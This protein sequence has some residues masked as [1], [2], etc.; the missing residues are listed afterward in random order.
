MDHG[1]QVRDLIEKAGGL[2]GTIDNSNINL[3]TE[4]LDGQVISIE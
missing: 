3:D 1:G 2:T 4:V